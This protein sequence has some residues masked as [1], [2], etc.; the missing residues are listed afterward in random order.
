[1]C[2][3]VAR[4]ARLHPAELRRELRHV[5]RREPAEDV[6]LY[7]PIKLFLNIYTSMYSFI[8][9]TETQKNHSTMVRK[10]IDRGAYILLNINQCIVTV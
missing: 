6:E 4:V 9:K 2:T 1:M 10:E 7:E 8:Y 5:V 3:G